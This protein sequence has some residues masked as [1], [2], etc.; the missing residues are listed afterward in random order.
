MCGI[1]GFSWEDKALVRKMT[2][3]IS[4]RGPDD[5]GYYTDT[6]V[7][8]GHRRLS[9]IDLSKLGHQ[10]MFNEDKSVTIVFNGEIYNYKH[11]KAILESKGHTFAS[12]SDTEVI[13]HGYEEYGPSICGKLEGMF[14]FALWDIKRK[15]LIVAR[16]RIG[17]KPLYYHHSKKGIA[18]ASEIKALLADPS[19]PRDIDKQTLSDYLTLR[20]SPE[21]R[22]I[23]SEVK[24]LLPGHYLIYQK[25]S[26]AIKQYWKLPEP[27]T[28]NKP[29]T[30]KVDALIEAAVKKR[31]MADVPLGVFLSGGLDSTAIV[32]YMSRLGVPIKTFSIGFNDNSNEAPYAKYVAEKFKTDHTE[33]ILD[34]DIVK[35]LPRVVWH[36]DEPLADPA[37]LP[38]FLLSEHVSK[39]VKV[40][41]SGEGGD[42]VFG[43]YHTFNTIDT[44]KKLRSIP[45]PVREKLLAPLADTAAQYFG[46]PRKQLFHLGA[47]VLRDIKDLPKAYTNLFYFPF[48]A[49]EKR[50]ALSSH[51]ADVSLT[52]PVE[53]M[54]AQGS[55]LKNNTLNYYFNEWLPNDLLMKVDKTSMAYG[56]EVRAPFLDVDLITYFMGLDNKFKKDRS[57]FRKT[58]SDMV[59]KKILARKKQGFTLP[60]SNWFTHHAF[61]DRI[62]PHIQDLAKRNIIRSE[63]IDYLLANPSAFKNDHRLWVLL[64]LELWFKLY[65]DEKPLKSVTV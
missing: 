4:H 43:G 33:I 11:L 23:F 41:L 14:T 54:L 48:N 53:T 64:N 24:K 40:V 63:Y 20:F 16:D 6:G 5:A 31:L 2:T 19:L 58:V 17:K 42:E 27:S 25:K 34:K 37:A 15:A 32:A 55:D 52:T 47:D 30:R 49:T 39:K 56:L 12:N 35:H 9:I 7:S 61:I 60:V 28:S 65:I 51:F 29:D 57:L 59:P 21:D 26:L 45:A 3:C 44:L 38:T 18:F 36:L 46:Y 62:R 22:T 8:L 10:P 50:K 13:I 1:T